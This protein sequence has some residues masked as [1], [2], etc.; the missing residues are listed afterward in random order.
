M[1]EI[2]F[3]PA[4]EYR[5]EVRLAERVVRKGDFARFCLEI[6]PQEVPQHSARDDETLLIEFEL[7]TCT[8]GTFIGRERSVEASRCVCRNV[9]AGAPT[10]N[11][12]GCQ[13]KGTWR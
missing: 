7:E 2:E 10:V 9:Q 3:E 4:A 6:A 8:P 13:L 12:V 11:F 1:R 5:A